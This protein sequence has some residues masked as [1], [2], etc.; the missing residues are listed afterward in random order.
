MPHRRPK[1]SHD[2]DLGFTPENETCPILCEA[3][4]MNVVVRAHRLS[5]D[6]ELFLQTAHEVVQPWNGVPG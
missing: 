1:S 2:V 6:W 3:A 5:D 4:S